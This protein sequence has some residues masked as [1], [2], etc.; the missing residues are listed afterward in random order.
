MKITNLF[1][2]FALVDAKE[3]MKVQRTHHQDHLSERRNLRNK[4]EQQSSFENKQLV[5]VQEQQRLLAEYQRLVAEYQRLVAAQEQLKRERKQQQQQL[6][7]TV[8]E[9]Q[10]LVQEQQQDH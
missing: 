5:E 9:Q 10:K 7:Q 8:Q 3:V 6:A 2:P 4:I 1:V